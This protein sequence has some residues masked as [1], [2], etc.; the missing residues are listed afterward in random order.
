MSNLVLGSKERYSQFIDFYKK[1][2]FN[3][4]L[5]TIKIMI[6]NN[7]NVNTNTLNMLIELSTKSYDL[8]NILNLFNISF[9]DYNSPLEGSSISILLKKYCV[10][11]LENRLFNNKIEY[12]LNLLDNKQIPLKNRM[13]SPIIDM[14]YNLKDELCI[15]RI[16]DYCI[17]NNV[18][19]LDID[20]CKIIVTLLENKSEYNKM[21]SIIKDF[22]CKNIYI[23]NES[24]AIIKKYTKKTK[25]NSYGICYKTFNKLSKMEIDDNTRKEILKFISNS[26][27]YSKSIIKFNEYIL[28]KDY[29]VVIDGANVGFY[30]Q[31]PD[32]GGILQYLQIDRVVDYF[33]K[34]GKKVLIILH[35]RHLKCSK[36]NKKI[37]D[38]WKEKK[39]IY[40]TPKRLND[41]IFWIYSS[42]SKKKCLIVT[43]DKIRDHKFIINKLSLN[44]KEL[45]QF[46]L[47][48]N[49]YNIK[50][51]FKEKL[52]INIPFDYSE[53]IQK[54]DNYLYFPVINNIIEWYY[55]NI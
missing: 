3:S 22:I 35:E 49:D 52:E 26:K 19:L 51:D 37:I 27:E 47:W 30:N 6:N 53:R 45:S 34:I 38:K 1:N 55:M 15:V 40:F 20:Y 10:L 41:D 5:S 39:I 54:I 28:T 44:E 17:K 14:Y 4:C 11:N 7:E 29:N 36:K 2:N 9:K 46:E 50:Y 48:F 8:D 25:I 24:I 23:N 16:Y 43:N 42:I 18:K 33:E 21:I 13:F 12:L 31:R 32:L